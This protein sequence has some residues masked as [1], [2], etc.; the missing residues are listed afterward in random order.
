MM[1]VYGGPLG[2]PNNGYNHKWDKQGDESIR[3]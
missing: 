3:S 2:Q 1:E